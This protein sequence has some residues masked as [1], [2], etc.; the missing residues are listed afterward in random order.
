MTL[1]NETGQRGEKIRVGFIEPGLV[2]YDDI[3]TILVDK[4]AL[5]KIAPT[6][7]GVPIFNEMHQDTT[8][9]DFD[10]GKA[11]GIMGGNV[12]FESDGLFWADAYIWN[13]K[14]LENIKK[15]GYRV[16]CAYDVTKWS[17]ATGLHNNIRYE[18]EVL[19][20]VMT[21]LAVV[22]RPRYERAKIIHNN[23]GG[24]MKL[25]FWKKDQKAEEKPSEVELVNAVTDLNGTD[26]TLEKVFELASAELKRQELANAKKGMEDD[27]IVEVAG[28]RITFKEA[29]ELASVALKNEQANS[30]KEEHDDGKHKDSPLE[31]CSYCKNSLANAKAEKDAEEVKKAA[32]TKLENEL[33]EKKRLEDLR[34]ASLKGN[35]PVMP[36]LPGDRDA[37]LAAGKSGYG[38]LTN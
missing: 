14:T 23:Q 6:I 2:A 32:A 28:K 36:A 17:D 8:S 10:R 11:D 3:G 9:T 20:G 7:E 29:K 22:K 21:H 4:D 16:S 1:E 26:T 24:N 30:M 19:N 37:R 31:S 13:H 34:N 15:N 27:E 12:A 38:P 33:A 18:N 5:N 35:A 25:M